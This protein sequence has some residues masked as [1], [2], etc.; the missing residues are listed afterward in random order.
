MSS[1]N[2]GLTIDNQLFRKQP[3]QK[4]PQEQ[5]PQL[6]EWLLV[7]QDSVFNCFLQDIRS[8]V[9][10]NIVIKFFIDPYLLA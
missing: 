3:L 4:I 6:A 9:A 1:E 5:C 7:R 10:K 2:D 8:V